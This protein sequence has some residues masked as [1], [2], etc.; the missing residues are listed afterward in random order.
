MT[1]A[2]PVCRLTAKDYDEALDFLNLVFSMSKKPHDFEK[3]LP[4]LA[5][6]DDEHMGHHLAVKAEGKIVSILGVYP[7]QVQVCGRELLFATVGNMATHPKWEGK[8]FMSA[9]YEA[10]IE[11]LNRIG[12]HA[13]RLGGKRQRYGRFGYERAGALYSYQFTEKNASYLPIN[14]AY[15]DVTFRKVTAGDPILADMLQV[16][17]Q[18]IVRA[19][20]PDTDHFFRVMSAWENVPHAAVLAD[21]T[22]VGYLSAAPDGSSFAEFG[23]V[24]AEACIEMLRAWFRWRGTNSISLSV[25]PWQLDYM[26]VLQKVSESYHISIPSSFR[27]SDWESVAGA[28]LALEATYRPLPDCSCVIEIKNYG[29]IRL[30]VSDG[31][32]A[33]EKTDCA[34]DLSLDDKDAARFLFGPHLPIYT[35]DI[36]TAAQTFANAC[37]PLPLSWNLQD[38]V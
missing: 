7:L 6:R 25:F 5:Y 34:P 38:R 22:V 9:L 17:N 27:I 36:P 1:T 20:R 33:C 32:T 21:G 24:S 18:N 10:S 2:Y 15:A 16:Y 4:N 19:I 30:A 23:A 14:D 8:G 3:M 11:E 26:R 12:A 31:K 37:L 35:A 13:A 28:Y 29:T